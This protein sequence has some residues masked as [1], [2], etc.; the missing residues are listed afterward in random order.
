MTRSFLKKAQQAAGQ[1]NRI[2]GAV[3]F[4]YFGSSFGH[5]G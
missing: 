1:R 5:L 2:Y 3:D 4:V